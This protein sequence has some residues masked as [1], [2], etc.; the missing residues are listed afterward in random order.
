MAS[1][2]NMTMIEAPAASRR[3]SRAAAAAPSQKAGKWLTVVPT[4]CIDFVN[5]THAT[6]AARGGPS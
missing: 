4:T 1:Y 2:R 6:P 5:H 3:A